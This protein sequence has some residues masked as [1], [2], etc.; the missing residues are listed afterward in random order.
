[1]PCYIGN[2]KGDHKA[3]GGFW[4]LRLSKYFF[5]GLLGL[6]TYF[7]DQAIRVVSLR[8]SVAFCL[9]LAVEAARVTRAR[10]H[11][12]ARV[13]SPCTRSGPDKRAQVGRRHWD[14][15]LYTGPC[16]VKSG[17]QIIAVPYPPPGVWGRCKHVPSPS[18]VTQVA[19]MLHVPQL[20]RFLGRATVFVGFGLSWE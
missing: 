10:A 19:S 15:F 16:I 3:F 17:K 6:G 20:P 9:G 5:L 11:I 13:V 14:A 7:G 8:I 1:M 4:V 18:R 12:H 2:R